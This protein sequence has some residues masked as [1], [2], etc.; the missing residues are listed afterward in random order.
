M[1]YYMHSFHQV[2]LES[3]EKFFKKTKIQILYY[4]TT[5]YVVNGFQ[6]KNTLIDQWGHSP[7]LTSKFHIQISYYITITNIT[8]GTLSSYS[9]NQPLFNLFTSNFKLQKTQILKL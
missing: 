6:I 5:K 7:P 4:S 9:L 2:L 1:H 8:T 3:D